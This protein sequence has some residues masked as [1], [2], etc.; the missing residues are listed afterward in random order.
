MGT[1]E[2]KQQG[3]KP[4]I[5]APVPEAPVFNPPPSGVRPDSGQDQ[6][7]GWRPGE[8][9]SLG[10]IVLYRHDLYEGGVAPAIITALCEDR[11]AVD[12]TVFFRNQAPYGLCSVKRGDSVGMWNWPPRV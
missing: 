10:R 3:D 8:K 9:P 12:L 2:E 6:G 7:M 11:N 5:T 1:E 4:N